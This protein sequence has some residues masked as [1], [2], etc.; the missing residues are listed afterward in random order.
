MLI[1]EFRMIIKVFKSF[2][3][4]CLLVFVLGATTNH[5]PLK[6]RCPIKI[7]TELGVSTLRHNSKYVMAIPVEELLYKK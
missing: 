2:V 5:V 6:F 1:I 4:T 7:R 3:N